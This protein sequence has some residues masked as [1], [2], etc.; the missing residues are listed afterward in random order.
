MEE[1]GRAVACWWKHDTLTNRVQSL[2][3]TT[4]NELLAPLEQRIARLREEGPLT[5]RRFA[6][7]LPGWLRQI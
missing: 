5:L 7:I 4:A 3:S 6:I 1:S 2:K